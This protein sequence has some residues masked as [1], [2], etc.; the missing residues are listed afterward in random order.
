MSFYLFLLALVVPWVGGYCSKGGEEVEEEETSPLP[1]LEPWFTGSLLAYSPN[2]VPGG[3]FNI[4]PYLFV[5]DAY[6]QYNNHWHAHSVPTIL[7][8]NPLIFAQFG[9]TKWLDILIVPQLFYTRNQ[10]KASTQFGDLTAGFDIQ[11]YQDPEERA[12]SVKLVLRASFPTGKFQHLN[13]KK[14]GTDSGGAGCYTPTIALAVGHDTH[15]SGFHFFNWRLNLAYSFSTP[16]HV[17]GFNTYGGGFGTSGTVHPGATY[18]ALTGFEYSLTRHWALALDITYTHGD[19]TR[20]S[21]NPGVD[22]TGAPA[23]VGGP[24][25]DQ[26]TLAPAIE[27]NFSEFLGLIAGP[28]FTVAGRNT[29]QFVS[30]V[31]ALNWY[32]SFIKKKGSEE[33]RIPSG[34]IR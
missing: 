19:K 15:L 34:G 30:G 6:G 25:F 26:F 28:W 29:Q 31:I 8:V 33:S 21:G 20:F 27:Y 1:T 24:S 16:L 18:Y 3:D 9:L 32:G 13:P 7:Y 22:A 23:M 5:T 14:N 2:V 17:K 10:G 4:E 11:L 12:P